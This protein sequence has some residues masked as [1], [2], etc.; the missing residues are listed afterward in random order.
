MILSHFK[1]DNTFVEFDYAQLEI[2]VLALATNCFQLIEDIN[3]G[4]DMHTYFASQIYDK[5]MDDVSKEERRIAKGF[6]FQLQYGAGSKGIAKFWNVDEALAEKFVNSYYNRYPEINLWQ[7]ANIEHAN[8]TMSHRGHKISGENVPSYFVP[9]IWKD[10]H[11]QR[12]LWYFILTASKGFR[13]T[14][15]ISPTKIKNYPIQGA[16]S[17]IM[18]FML[19][20]LYVT[21]CSSFPKTK[22]LNTV[23]DSILL[24]VGDNITEVIEVSKKILEGVGDKLYTL[25]K[26]RSPVSFPV[27]VSI[28]ETLEQVKKG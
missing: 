7:E 5:S 25:F 26:I 10:L 8:K 24:D 13:D 1:A 27:D 3:S 4:L 15:S 14:F 9:V 18:M 6:S 23:H 17:D 11:T 2:R 16:A 28:G 19:N 20:E 21:L 22:L 12:P